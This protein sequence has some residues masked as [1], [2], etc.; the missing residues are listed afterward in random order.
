M[1]NMVL[2]A[3]LAAMLGFSGIGG[4]IADCGAPHG[5]QASAPASDA[6]ATLPTT[7]KT[8]GG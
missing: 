6:S 8:D 1:R 2:L 7:T 3:L 5:A 4:A